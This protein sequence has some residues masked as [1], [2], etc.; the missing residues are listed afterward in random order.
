MNALIAAARAI[1]FLSLMVIFGGSAFTALLHRA[2]LPAPSLRTER[3]LFSVAALLAIASAALWFCLIAGQMSGNW[4]GSI[5]PATLELVASE[6]RFGQIAVVRAVAMAALL[7]ACIGDMTA[8]RKA[9]PLL[10]GLLLVLLA[11]ISHAA[12]ADADIA[13]AGVTTD[14]AHLLTAGFWLGGLV[15]LA[16]LVI[17]SWA[18]RAALIAALRLFSFWGSL[19]VAVL[20]ITG[21]INAVSIVPVSAASLHDAY[22]NLLVVKVA[23]AGAMIALAV[24]NR[25]RF[26]PALEHG[27]RGAMRHLTGSIGIEIALGIAVVGIAAFLGLMGPH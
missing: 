25:W 16:M 18:D 12:A 21:V 27:R 2:N 3:I 19:A 14:A 9:V 7:A 26:A 4:R 20:V 15:I 22:F 23:L 5:D 24:L 8:H 6:T 17:H 13:I 10:A 11:P 1:H